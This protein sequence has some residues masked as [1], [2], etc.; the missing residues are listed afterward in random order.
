MADFNESL[1]IASQ[2]ILHRELSEEERTEFLELG[3]ALGMNNVEDYLYILM[4]FKRHSD[5]VGRSLD[6]ISALE[7]KINDTLESSIERILGEGAARIGENMGEV[8]ADGAD[9]ILTSYGEYH[10][11]RGHTVLVCFTS[12]VSTLA[13]WLGANNFLRGAPS[14]SALENFLFLPGGWGIFICGATYSLLWS[15]DNWGK[16]KRTKLYR[17]FLGVQV[18]LLLILVLILL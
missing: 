11:H 8:V 7:R 2:A 6:G 17:I 14:G 13:Y 4:V 1:K 5:V 3:A 9:K 12:L 18:F 16:I 10:T 15:G